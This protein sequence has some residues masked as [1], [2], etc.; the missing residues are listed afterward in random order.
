MNDD[1]NINNDSDDLFKEL[2]QQDVTNVKLIRT[3][4]LVN[5][6]N[7][8]T[9]IDNSN[10]EIIE[11]TQSDS[12]EIVENISNENEDSNEYETEDVDED[13]TVEYIEENKPINGWAIFSLVFGIASLIFWLLPYIGFATS[14]IG[15]ML[16]A[17]S[18]KN[19]NTSMSTIA[20]VMCVVG[21]FIAL[22]YS[23][24]KVVIFII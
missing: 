7:I 15:I 20:I 12:N 10:S 16:A 24:F 22:M 6:E 21:I 1:N 3:D 18:K 2:A 13:E 23:I 5:N 14:I 11:N 17:I 9:N 4:N 19:S 8:K